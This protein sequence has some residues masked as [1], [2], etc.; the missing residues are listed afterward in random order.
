M[1]SDPDKLLKRHRELTHSESLKVVSHVQRQSGDWYLNTLMLE[2]YDVPFQY[3]RQVKYKNLQGGRVNLTYYP[4][5]KNVAGMAVEV[6]N[7]VRVRRA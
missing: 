7:V 1:K 5:T 2:G 3:K 4:T 6:M